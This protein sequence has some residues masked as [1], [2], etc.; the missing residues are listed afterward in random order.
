MCIP[1]FYIIMDDTGNVDRT[2]LRV[3]TIAGSTC[4]TSSAAVSY[5][6][7][8]DWRPEDFDI[9]VGATF[10]LFLLR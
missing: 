10:L 7:Y 9:A 6:L 8:H 2:V 3:V 1:F 5:A 4:G